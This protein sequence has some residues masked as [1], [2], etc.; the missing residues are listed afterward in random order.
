MHTTVHD[1]NGIKL[2]SSLYNNSYTSTSSEFTTP[3]T[4]ILGGTCSSSGVVSSSFVG[5]IYYFKVWENDVLVA[6]WI[7]VRMNGI[8]GF[9]DKLKNTFIQPFEQYY[10][11]DLE[12]DEN[13]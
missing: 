4:I 12:Q 11:S 3:Y 7:P 2:D 1:K 5:Y 13:E 6:D 10:I 9:L 8:N